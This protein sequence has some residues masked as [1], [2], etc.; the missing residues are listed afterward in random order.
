M[1]LLFRHDGYGIAA[2]SHSCERKFGGRSHRSAL[3][4]IGFGVATIVGI[5]CIGVNS[6]FVLTSLVEER[7]RQVR[8]MGRIARYT[9]HK[10]FIAAFGFACRRDVCHGFG[11]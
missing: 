8:L 2:T 1:P 10:P 3:Y 9:A 6:G 11:F 5:G 7:Q 4:A